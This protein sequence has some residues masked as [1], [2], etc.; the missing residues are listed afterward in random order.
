MATNFTYRVE[1]DPSTG[2]P[3]VWIDANGNT[4]FRQPH[5]PNAVLDPANPLA[6]LWADEAEATAWAE[7]C[8]AQL[9]EQEAAAIA[10]AE[11]E[12]AAAAAAAQVAEEDRARLVRIEE[13]LAQLLAK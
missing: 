13:M 12:E 1:T 5:H 10:A 3:L 9:L 8:I 7:E 2:R 6:G 4:V 11:A